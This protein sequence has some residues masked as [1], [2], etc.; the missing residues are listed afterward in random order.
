MRHLIIYL[1]VLLV[2]ALFLVYKGCEWMYNYV[3]YLTSDYERDD[4]YVN[5]QLDHYAI[6]RW[7]LDKSAEILKG[8]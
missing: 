8:A 3:L 5:R 4:D 1:I 2:V 6:K 7:L